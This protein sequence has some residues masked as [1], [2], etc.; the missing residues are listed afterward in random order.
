M[1][2]NV[3][4]DTAREDYLAK[5]QL[6]KGAAGWVLLAGLGVSY[7]ISGDFSGW[8]LGLAEGGWFGMV[9]AFALMAVLFFTMSLGLAEMASAIPTAGGGYG[10]ARRA[11]GRLPG[12][13]LGMSVLLAY[14]LITAAISTFIAG[15]V[16]ALG[17]LPESFPEWALYVIVYVIF[18]AVHIVGTGEALKLMF[19]ITGVAVAA[20]LAFVIGMAPSFDS[21]NLFDIS[22]TDAPGAS[23]LLP[24]GVSGVLSS[25]IF[26][27]WMFGALE[28]LPLASEEAADA[29]RDMPRGIMVA[30]GVLFLFGALMLIFVPGTAGA[31][32]ISASDN[33][34]PEA[35]RAVHGADSVLATFVN[36]A[37]LFGLVASFFSII[38]AYSRQLFALS[39]AGYIPRTFSV[40]SRRKT[41]VLALILPGIIGLI[42]V[43]AVN[44]EVTILMNFAIF[45]L[46]TGFVLFNLSHI[47]L[48]FREPEL[49]RAYRTPGGVVTT[50]IAL[51]LSVVAW[52]STF[53]QDPPAAT[54]AACTL[55]VA[56]AYFYFYAR[57]R[58]VSSA[59]EEEFSQIA[60]A[61]Q[62]LK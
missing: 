49:P 7:V 16:V 37:G 36:W 21:S 43:L 8:N 42:C 52:V 51:V 38:Y 12:F 54:A 11:L 14:T 29:K 61:S 23:S 2:G 19:V 9:I 27:I 41:P 31:A 57:H 15:Y 60:E 26:G 1:A 56:V 39:R 4:L 40:T 10:F 24:F 5:R 62:D 45:C 6:R 59:P 50:S 30:M 3:D 33:P 32:L 47:V 44:G 35:V 55:L 22:V 13:I 20:M 25:L 17:I 46:T 53:V 48:R 34:L 18:T 28:A 58:L